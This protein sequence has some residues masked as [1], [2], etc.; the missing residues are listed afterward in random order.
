LNK[1]LNYL[2][3]DIMDRILPSFSTSFELVSICNPVGILLTFSSVAW[4]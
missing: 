1:T 2:T 4:G 3:F